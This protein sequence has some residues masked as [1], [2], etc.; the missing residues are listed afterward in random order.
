MT[1]SAS[2]CPIATCSPSNSSLALRFGAEKVF[3][4]RSST[5]A[6]DIRAYTS[7]ELKYAFDCITQ[8]DT[9]ELCYSALGRAGDRHV[10]LEPFRETVAPLQP[11]T[12]DPSWVMIL[13]IFGRKV[14]LDG[15]Y[16]RDA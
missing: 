16:G 5:C 7:N 8:A 14:A 13:T 11:P 9:T 6:A 4:Y 10:S 12:I 1:C 2:L 15:D 3:D